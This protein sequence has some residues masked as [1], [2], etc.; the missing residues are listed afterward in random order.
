MNT[1]RHYIFIK[2]FRRIVDVSNTFKKWLGLR[3]MLLT[4]FINGLIRQ[5]WF[6]K[7]LF[8]RDTYPI[9]YDIDSP[10]QRFNWPLLVQIFLGGRYCLVLY[11]PLRGPPVVAVS[12]GHQFWA[13]QGKSHTSAVVSF[14]RLF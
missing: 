1:I 13:L 2:Y 6:T 12:C 9:R 14:G 4:C 7:I 11:S 8:A 3:L 10:G 5:N